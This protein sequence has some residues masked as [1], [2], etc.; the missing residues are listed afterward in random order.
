MKKY[1]LITTILVFVGCNNQQQDNGI[2]IMHNFSVPETLLFELNIQTYLTDGIFD[3]DVPDSLK[4][5]P[6]DKEVTK[7]LVD[8]KYKVFYEYVIRQDGE[9]I[10]WDK[11]SLLYDHCRFYVYGNLDLQNNVKSII[12]WEIDRDFAFNCYH[13]RCLWLFNL[14][15]DKL[16]SVALLAFS[17]VYVDPPSSYSNTCIRNGIFMETK[18][19][20]EYWFIENIGQRKWNSYEVKRVARYRVNDSGFIEFL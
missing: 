8:I 14:R 5:Y 4:M 1:I 17:S 19:S 9:G 13:S 18:I 3:L 2:V 20:S 15:E 11:D 16:C 10:F 7:Q 6:L 12:L